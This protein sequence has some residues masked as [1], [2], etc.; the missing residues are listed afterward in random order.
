MLAPTKKS[1]PID[2]KE[3]G[4]MARPN[5]Q[6]FFSVESPA[7]PLVM[8]VDDDPM[9]LASVNRQLARK[10]TSID[11]VF[12]D[13]GVKALAEAA[14]RT[15]DI[16]F[17]DLRMPVM[18]GRAFLTEFSKRYPK[19]TRFAITGQLAASELVELETLVEQ[20]F[21]KPIDCVQLQEIIVSVISR[22]DEI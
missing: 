3:V 14:K 15:P 16:L 21:S 20:V 17:S 7:K 18:D 13:G 4:T 19:A 8:F 11:F 10:L 6:T 2:F 9:I 1:G 12:C 5:S 22:P